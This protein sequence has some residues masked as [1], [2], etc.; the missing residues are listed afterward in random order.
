MELDYQNIINQIGQIVQYCLPLAILI[1]LIE[2][3]MSMIVRAATGKG[4]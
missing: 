4:D 1:G 3:L 2:R